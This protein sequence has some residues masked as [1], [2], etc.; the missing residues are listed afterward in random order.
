LKNFLRYKLLCS[1][2]G[3]SDWCKFIFGTVR[4]QATI[5]GYCGHSV[6]KEPSGGWRCPNG[7]ISLASTE[8]VRESKRIQSKIRISW[9]YKPEGKESPEWEIRIWGWLPRNNSHQNIPDVLR[10]IRQWLEQDNLEVKSP[11]GH[12]KVTFP[13]CSLRWWPDQTDLS[14]AFKELRQAE[15]GAS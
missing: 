5:C 3:E 7:G 8:V 4:G 1:G 11:D 9:A 15:V 13:K 2:N 12:I 10:S 14:D 6:N